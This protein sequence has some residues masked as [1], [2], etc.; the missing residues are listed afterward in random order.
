MPGV[1]PDVMD[2]KKEFLTPYFSD[3]FPLL[4]M[5][6]QSDNLSYA[7]CRKVGLKMPVILFS[8]H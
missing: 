3:C 6:V 4:N 8:K 1:L 5:R 2:T 7:G